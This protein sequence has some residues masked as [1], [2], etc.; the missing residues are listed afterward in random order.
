[1]KVGSSH[2]VLQSTRRA[3]SSNDLAQQANETVVGGCVLVTQAATSPRISLIPRARW[4]MVVALAE[5][6]LA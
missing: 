2:W 5:A 1:V 3:G 6:D 4:G